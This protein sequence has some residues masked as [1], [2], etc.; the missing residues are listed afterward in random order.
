MRPHLGPALPF[1]VVA[2]PGR[3]TGPFEKC[4]KGSPEAPVS[5]SEQ[6]GRE[7]RAQ[8]VPVSE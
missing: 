4:E 1:L 2:V 8:M 7:G 5:M 6:S 3:G